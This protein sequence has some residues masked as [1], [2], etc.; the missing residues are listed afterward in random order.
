M[1]YAGFWIRVA[2]YLIDGILL[3]ILQVLIGSIFGFSMG[4]MTGL[5]P[6]AAEAMAASGGGI[7]TLVMTLIGVVYFVVLESSNWQATLGKKAV[8]IVVTDTN[9]Q[10]ISWLRALGRYFAKILSALILLIGFI[11]VAFTDKKQGLHDLIC[12]TLVVKGQPGTHGT[13]GVFD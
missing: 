13:E 4:A 6:I 3:L 11:M 10:R 7:F 2:A 12:S 8:G 9:G 1:N 5:D